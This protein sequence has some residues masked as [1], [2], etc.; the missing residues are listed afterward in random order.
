[1]KVVFVDNFDSFTFNLVDEFSRS[2]C[3]VEVWR[4]TAPAAHVL[5]RATSGVEPRLLVLS[6]G[7]GR[8][9]Q[10]DGAEGQATLFTEQRPEVLVH[11]A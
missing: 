1:M 2:G 7:P 4:N 9:E 10:A 6:P 8:P 11:H 3:D 5:E